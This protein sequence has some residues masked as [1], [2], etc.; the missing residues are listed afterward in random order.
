MHPGPGS[1]DNS[2]GSTQGARDIGLQDQSGNRHWSVTR[3]SLYQLA[4]EFDSE[5]VLEGENVYCNRRSRCN[6]KL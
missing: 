4:E 3:R 2:F 6:L 5:Q 1:L